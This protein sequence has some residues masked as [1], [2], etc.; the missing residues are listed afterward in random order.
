MQLSDAGLSL[1]KSFEQCRLSAYPDQRGI[2]TIGWGHTA[3]VVIG[4]TCN[5]DQAD[6]WL[7]IDT[8]FAA[9]AVNNT[10]KVPI[11]QPEF[12]ALVSFTY[13]VGIGSEAHSTLL[14]LINQSNFTAAAAEFP[15]WN[16]CKGVVDPGLTRRRAAEM[17]LFLQE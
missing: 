11:A 2:P 15:K 3:G 14:Q 13:N 7:K 6:C 5:Q 12:D 1:I 4:M 17:A 8:A 10:V 16:H 9:H